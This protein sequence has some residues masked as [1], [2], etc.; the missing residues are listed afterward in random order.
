M[1]KRIRKK[2]LKRTL[3][4]LIAAL[5]AYEAKREQIFQEAAQNLANACGKSHEEFVIALR[6][7][8]EVVSALA[9]T[10]PMPRSVREYV[11]ANS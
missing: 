11:D 8:M 6:R 5:E 4:Q 1:N 3:R 7:Y 9:S 2:Q 10:G